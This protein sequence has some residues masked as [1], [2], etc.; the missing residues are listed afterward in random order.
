MQTRQPV[1]T[2]D[3]L[4]VG[5]TGRIASVDWDAL[6]SAE[7]RRLRELGLFEGVDVEMLHRG[8]LF[9][10]DPLAIR[11][12]RMRVVIRTVHAAAVTLDGMMPDARA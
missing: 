8:A 11:I 3:H 10:R 1:T 6:A 4:P 12:G 7:G 9:F 5:S 2:L